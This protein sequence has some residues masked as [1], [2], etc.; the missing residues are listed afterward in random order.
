[1]LLM[2]LHSVT[3]AGGAGRRQHGTSCLGQGC[4][5]EYLRDPVLDVRRRH[6][7]LGHE[8]KDQDDEGV[9][10]RGREAQA[11]RTSTPTL[12]LLLALVESCR[13]CAVALPW[14]DV[15]AK[16]LA[17]VLR[18]DALDV[19]G[20]CAYPVADLAGAAAK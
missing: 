14:T 20:H 1:M 19:L 13:P 15:V 18:G 10:D 6:L 17:V 11:K 16:V 7:L 9:A 8:T 2:S 12:H 5:A 3:I 4:P